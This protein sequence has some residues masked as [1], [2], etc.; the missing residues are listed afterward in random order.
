MTLVTLLIC[1]TSVVASCAAPSFFKAVTVVGGDTF[2]DGGLVA[3]D[4]SELAR[5]EVRALEQGERLPDYSLSLGTGI[6]RAPPSE[7]NAVPRWPWR[8]YDWAKEQMEAE[9]IYQKKLKGL[10]QAEAERCFRLNPAFS[11]PGISL[12][13]ENS[14][15]TLRRMTEEQL[16]ASPTL[17]STLAKLKLFIICCSFYFE[18]TH[19]PIY[20]GDSG[21]YACAGQIMTRWQDDECISSKFDCVTKGCRFLVNGV[22]YDSILP[23]EIT[24]K[25][26]SL[27]APFDIS[28]EQ[29]NGSC[30]SI[31]GFPSSANALLRIQGHSNLRSEPAQRWKRRSRFSLP[32]SKRARADPVL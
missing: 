5:Q 14:I 25:L 2:Q 1:L 26:T 20:D 18:F 21:V 31:S 30:G 32:S 22:P 28:F 4:P 12:D 11:C 15:P 19:F 24:F 27:R 16:V 13:D 7:R 23:V 10:T 6:F 3:N 29:R 9:S 8:L 17:T